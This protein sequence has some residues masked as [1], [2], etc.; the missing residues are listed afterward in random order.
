VQ[1]GDDDPLQAACRFNSTAVASRVTY[2]RS[3]DAKPGEVAVD[4]ESADE[5]RGDWVRRR[6]AEPRWRSGMINRGHREAGVGRHLIV[7]ISDHPGGG[8]VV[9]RVRR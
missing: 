1:G 9:E 5:Q 8:G 7:L 2:E 6:L 4:G 3:A